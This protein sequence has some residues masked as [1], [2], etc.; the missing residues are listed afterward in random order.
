AR[1]VARGLP[2]D[3]RTD[4]TPISLVATAPFV[5]LVGPDNPA[6]NLRQLGEALR[7]QPDT[8]CVTPGAGSFTHLT[9]VLLTRAMGVGCEAVHYSDPGQAIAD[10]RAGR[11]QLYVNTVPTGLPAV[12]ENRARALAITA[13]RRLS[14]APEIPTA[15]EAGLP[16]FT[17]E[18]WWGLFAPRGLP[19]ALK[20]S[21]ERAAMEAA[22]NPA[23]AARLRALG[24]EP[25]GS[26][27][28]ELAG[29]LQ[30]DDAKWG[31]AARAAGIASE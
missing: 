1:H 6:Q 11:I 9:T 16:G 22:R 21:L 7:S 20:V 24:A 26:T 30:A 8:R 19:E 31:E 5:V 3:P 17:A 2:F 29:T 23:V 27:A 13:G 18:A 10:L 28:A 14:T 4:F 12:R 25:V 15:A